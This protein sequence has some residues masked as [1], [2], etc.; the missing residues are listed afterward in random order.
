VNIKF[1]IFLSNTSVIVQGCNTC[2]L[3][4]Y[5]HIFGFNHFTTYFFLTGI[6]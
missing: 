5:Q 4:F 2:H 3:W 1:L 6:L